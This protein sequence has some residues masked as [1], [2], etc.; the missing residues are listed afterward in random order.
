MEIEIYLL[1]MGFLPNLKGFEFVIQAINLF[2]ED[3]DYKRNITK[4]LY[5]KLA[6]IFGETPS[7]VERAMRHS[8]KRAKLDMTVSE[9]IAFAEIETRKTKNKK[10]KK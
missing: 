4:M 8:I 5:P 7:K 1:D 6:E 10:L 2:R 3:K 9:F